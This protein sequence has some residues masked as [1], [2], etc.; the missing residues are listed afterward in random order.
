M[1]SEVRRE[2]AIRHNLYANWKQGAGRVRRNMMDR[3]YDVM[4]AIL[5]RLEEEREHERRA[6]DRG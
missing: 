1:I 2:L 3:Q 6:V 4:S 5:K